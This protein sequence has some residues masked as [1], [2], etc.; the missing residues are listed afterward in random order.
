MVLDFENFNYMLSI[1]PNLPLK[2][3]DILAKTL[4]KVI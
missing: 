4:K 1:D 2:F 3:W